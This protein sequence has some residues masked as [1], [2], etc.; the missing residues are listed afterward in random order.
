MPAVERLYCSTRCRRGSAAIFFENNEKVMWFTGEPPCFRC[1]RFPSCVSHP[2]AAARVCAW[3]HQHY[4]IIVSFG[5]W[6]VFCRCVALALEDVYRR[7]CHWKIGRN[8]GLRSRI[9]SVATGSVYTENLDASASTVAS[10]SRTAPGDGQHVATRGR[11]TLNVCR[12][13]S[14]EIKKSSPLTELGDGGV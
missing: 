8:R 1:C 6:L 14:Q 3:F 4:Y 7:M 5:R 2:C 12:R 13:L 10:I 9:L 11:H